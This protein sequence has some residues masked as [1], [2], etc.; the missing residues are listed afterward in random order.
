LRKHVKQPVHG[1]VLFRIR[2]NHEPVAPKARNVA[3]AHVN[4]EPAGL[5][6]VAGHLNREVIGGGFVHRPFLFRLHQNVGSQGRKT[7]ACNQRNENREREKSML[8][9]YHVTR[10]N[11]GAQSRN[12]AIK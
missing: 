4:F 11:V 1:I 9:Q 5:D 12:A 6:A 3:A 10:K 8:H 7:R 2:L